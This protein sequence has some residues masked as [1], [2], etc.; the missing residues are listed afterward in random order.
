M[1][2]ER[3]FKMIWAYAGLSGSELARK[4]GITRQ[5]L[6]KYEHGTAPYSNNPVIKNACEVC[7]LT[8]EDFWL[9]AE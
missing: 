7:G 6:W 5:Q 8:T 2:I 4:I 3:A 1:N 9:F